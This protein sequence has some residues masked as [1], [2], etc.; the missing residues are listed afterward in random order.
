MRRLKVGD[1]VRVTAGRDKGK[2]GRVQ[3]ILD[4]ENRVLVEGINVRVRH[5]R[6]SQLNT[7]GGRLEKEMPIHLSNVMPLNADGKPTRVKAMISE[8]DGK[9]VKNRVAVGGGELKS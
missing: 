4:H 6:P 1:L 3:R 5:T 9:Q 8:V 2:E 7:E